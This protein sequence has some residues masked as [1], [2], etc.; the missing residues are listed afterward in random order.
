[1]SLRK[2]HDLAL[3]LSYYNAA[4]GSKWLTEM[5]NRHRVEAE[6]TEL[7]NK[8]HLEGYDVY[9]ELSSKDY[10]LDWIYL[11]DCYEKQT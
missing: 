4:E 11:K 10:L 1:M 8:L 3:Q 2:L 9:H 7:L 6:F 5:D